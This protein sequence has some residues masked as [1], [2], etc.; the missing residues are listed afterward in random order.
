M[1]RVGPNAGNSSENEN[2]RHWRVTLG[3]RRPGNQ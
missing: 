3:A 1:E 2:V